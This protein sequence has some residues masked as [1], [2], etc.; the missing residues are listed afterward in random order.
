MP[1]TITNSF[2]C[3][4]CGTAADPIESPPGEVDMFPPPQWAMFQETNHKPGQGAVSS[5]LAM[6]PNCLTDFDAFMSSAPATQPKGG[7]DG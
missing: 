6:C 4:R 5:T 3:D 1:V 7:N 2:V